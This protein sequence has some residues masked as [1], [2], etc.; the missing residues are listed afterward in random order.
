M[1]ALWYTCKLPLTM[2]CASSAQTIAVLAGLGVVAWRRWSAR[3]RE[4]ACLETKPGGNAD[5]FY[6]AS[7]S[8]DGPNPAGMGGPP[9]SSPPGGPTALAPTAAPGW[10]GTPTMLVAAAPA[11]STGT[12]SQ[13]NK[14]TWLTTWQADMAVGAPASPAAAGFAGALT[15][16]QLLGGSPAST[17]AT[18]QVLP[19]DRPSAATPRSPGMLPV[20]TPNRHAGAGPLMHTHAS[21]MPANPPSACLT[22][23]LALRPPCCSATSPLEGSC[24]PTLFA[25][26]NNEDPL[27]TYIRTQLN[28]MPAQ[29]ASGVH[30]PS[31][32][33]TGTTA[34]WTIAFN[35]LN[36]IQ[37]IGQGSFGRVF[38]AEW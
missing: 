16:D 37:P 17:F 26:S 29:R 12:D 21:G 33:R 9:G 23:L 11:S 30:T 7:R 34:L 20:G 18:P 13:L 28:S 32:G 8:W 19:L 25:Q 24:S 2:A 1:H 15:A 14:P 6:Q 5:E 10:A 31:S 38:R 35:D 4:A 27:L 22:T 36:I 3:R